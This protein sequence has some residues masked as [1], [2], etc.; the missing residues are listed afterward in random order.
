ML[1]DNNPSSPSDL[2][3]AVPCP[4]EYSG[5]PECSY[6]GECYTDEHG[7]PACRCHRWYAGQRCQVN[8][9]VLLIALAS[10]GALLAALLCVCCYFCCRRRRPLAAPPLGENWGLRFC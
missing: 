4:G 1:S 9:R 5:C 6:S 2:S 8:L 7:E 3:A 10:A